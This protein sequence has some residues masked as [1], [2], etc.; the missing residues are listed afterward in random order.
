MLTREQK[1]EFTKVVG[2]LLR[3]K[4]KLPWSRVCGRKLAIWTFMFSKQLS[5]SHFKAMSE[6]FCSQHSLRR[7]PL[8]SVL[9][10]RFREMSVVLR[11]KIGRDQ[12]QFPFYK[13]VRLMQVSGVLFLSQQLRY[14]LREPREYGTM[15]ESY[16]QNLKA[17]APCLTFTCKDSFST[18]AGLAQSV[19]RLTAEQ[20]LLGSIPGSGPTLYNCTVPQM[21]PNRK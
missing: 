13:G 15:N 20:E 17:V 16:R 6:V 2:E 10:V 5:R 7:T 19:E 8:G 21:I 9:S 12:L 3:C 18:A 11:I 4:N 1:G 14:I